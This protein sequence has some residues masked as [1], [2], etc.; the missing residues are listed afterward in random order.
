MRDLIELFENTDTFNL[1]KS[2]QIDC[3]IANL[4]SESKPLD[5]K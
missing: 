1:Y 2:W 3:D 4:I 5:E